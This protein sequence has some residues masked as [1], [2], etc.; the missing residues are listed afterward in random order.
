MA[1]QPSPA[2]LDPQVLRRLRREWLLTNGRGGFASSSLAGVPTRCY[3]GLLVAAAR[4][5]LERW[6]LLHSMLERVEVAGRAHEFAAYE[7]ANAFHPQGF[8]HITRVAMDSSHPEHPWIRFE[9][10]EGGVRLTKL[11]L[12]QYGRDAVWIRYRV[13]ADGDAPLKFILY[14]M[15]AMRD[16]HGTTHAF[17]EGFSVQ[18]FSDHVA[19]NAHYEGPRLWLHAR[20]E[21]GEHAPVRYEDT[22]DWWYGI[23][24]R[25]ETERGLGDHEDLFVPGRFQA[26]GQGEIIL[27]VQAQAAFRDGPPPPVE[28][29]LPVDFD[30]PEPPEQRPIEER[31]REAT[32]LFVVQRHRDQ[33]DPLTTILA[34]YHW[35]GDWGRDTF[36]ALPGLLLETE[37]YT[38]ARQVLEVF[39]SVQQDGMIPNKFSDYGAGADYNSVDASLWYLH[40]AQLYVALTGDEEAWQAFLGPACRKIVE[41][42]RDGTQFNI[43]LDADGLIACGD[44][45]TQLTWMDAKCDGTVFTPRFGKP[46]EI[47]ALWYHGLCALAKRVESMEPEHASEYRELAERCRASF[48]PAYWNEETGCLNDVVGEGFSACIRPNQV[49][50]VS[51]EHSPLDDGQKR[52]VLEVVERELLTPFGLRSLSPKDPAYR[53]RYGGGPYERDSAYHQGT[54]WGWLIG[55]YIEA[56]LRVHDFT[57]EAKREARGKLTALIEHLD[58]A[59]LNSVSEVFDGQAPHAPRGCV[60]QAWSVSEL[61]R[62]W[63]LTA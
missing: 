48:V 27:T 33:G 21:D 29:N 12:M 62:A 6:L 50:A 22:G 3:H 41:A 8:D 35:F 28:M 58:D 55:P 56:Y 32:R 18:P 54:V 16:F 9:Y 51:L 36:I 24:L 4:P 49:F 45:S 2:S 46:V 43:H 40:A 47:N 52:A 20:R 53:P 31:L 5:P 13:Q 14:P 61:Y 17:A 25:V 37:R 60:A 23:K 59:G 7:F 1:S 63:R 11:V 19:V 15:T 57:A 34:G 10:E 38:E 26:E 39:A 42:F 44:A 30:T